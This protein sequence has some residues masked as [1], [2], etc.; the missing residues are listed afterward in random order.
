MPFFQTLSVEY[1]HTIEGK[2]DLLAFMKE[3]GY[4]KVG[5]VHY[6]NNLANDYMFVHK[7]AEVDV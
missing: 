7:D 1:I 4:Q 3:K 2:N 5:E 6:P